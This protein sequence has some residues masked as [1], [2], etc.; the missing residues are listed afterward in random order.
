MVVNRPRKLY[1]LKRKY[2]LM[3]VE[4]DRVRE[5]IGSNALKEERLLG[6]LV[7]ARDRLAVV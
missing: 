6:I 4:V 7:Q 1:E 2:L 3:E 5:D